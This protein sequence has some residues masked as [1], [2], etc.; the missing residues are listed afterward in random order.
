[1]AS[2]LALSPQLEQIQ[3]EIRDN[4]RALAYV[5][6]F[7]FSLSL[8]LSLLY[9]YIYIK[10]L[11]MQSYFAATL[12]FNSVQCKII[13]IRHFTN[14]NL[15]KFTVILYIIC[16]CISEMAF[17]NWIKSKILIDKVNSLRNSPPR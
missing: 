17:K 11:H 9:I 6:T 7:H 4:F 15:H 1:M 16:P 8:S 10:L 13:P 12:Q 2:E 3:G 5:K 14:L